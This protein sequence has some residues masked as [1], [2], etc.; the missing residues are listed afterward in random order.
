MNAEIQDALGKLWEAYNFG[1]IS[2]Q[3]MKTIR[4]QYLRGQIKDIDRTIY[5]AAERHLAKNE[6]QEY[7]KSRKG[8]R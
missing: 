6:R 2:K 7:N 4:G 5:K 1:G 3:Q 8:E